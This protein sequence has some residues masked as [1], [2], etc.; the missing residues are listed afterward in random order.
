M[1]KLS[2]L[3]L[4]EVPPPPCKNA[5]FTLKF[6]LSSIPKIPI[7]DNVRKTG[8]ASDTVIVSLAIKLAPS[9]E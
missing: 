3:L 2:N 6:G 8:S 9:V 5:T 1:V 4:P 7:Y